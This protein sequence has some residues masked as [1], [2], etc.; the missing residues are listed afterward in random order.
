MPFDRRGAGWHRTVHQ[1]KNLG[2]PML[3]TKLAA[4]VLVA[5]CVGPSAAFAHGLSGQSDA[6]QD[7]TQSSDTN[8]DQAKKARKLETIT[9]TGSLIPQT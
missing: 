3:K 6:Q 9:V 8:G 1:I 4:A 5:L 2:K 7:T